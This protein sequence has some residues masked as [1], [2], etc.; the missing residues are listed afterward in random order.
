MSRI[1]SDFLPNLVRR[2]LS[3]P[4]AAQYSS[5]KQCAFVVI[6]LTTKAQ[7]AML[8]TES[9]ILLK[10]QQAAGLD[11]IQQPYNPNWACPIPPKENRLRVRIEAGEKNYKTAYT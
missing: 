8:T 9:D 6:E 4:L 3:T 5:N 7:P 11:K 10:H 2:S 1:P